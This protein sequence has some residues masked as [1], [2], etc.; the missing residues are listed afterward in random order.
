[1]TVEQI[2]QRFNADGILARAAAGELSVAI[3]LDKRMSD[4]TCDAKGYPRG[5]RKQM[6]AY[7]DGPQ[8]V[9]LAHQVVLPDGTLG[10]SGIP[11]PKELLVDGVL[12][13]V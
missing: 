9:A 4:E 10:A 6:I 13:Y 7:Y 11:D 1:M 3:R 8:R 12:W 2:R 5:T